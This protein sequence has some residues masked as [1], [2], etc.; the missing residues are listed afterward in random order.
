MRHI[1]QVLNTVLEKDFGKA[2]K[3]IEGFVERLKVEKRGLSLEY[4]FLPD[5]VELYGLVDFEASVWAFEKITPLASC[6]FAVRPFIV[7]YPEKM[8]S[9]MLDWSLSTNHLLR[10]LA[11]EGSRPRLPWAMALL[12]FK[13]DP[14]KM[15]PILENLK[16]DESEFVRKSVANSLNDISKDNPEITLEIVKNW[17]G[18][19]K[20]V[21]RIL[22]HGSRTL[23]KQGNQKA[24]SLFGYGSVD[25]INLSNFSI[26][27]KEIKIGD[28]L[29]FSFVLENQNSKDVNIRLEYA[30]YYRKANESLFK[31]VF[32]ISEKTYS[33]KSVTKIQRRRSFQAFSTRKYHSG[34]HQVAIIVNGVEFLSESFMLYG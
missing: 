6:E 28:Y 33:K 21:D 1:A 17:Q 19:S 24:L 27:K 30:V 16:N 11:S 15:L 2:V 26:A 25:N 10:R 8:M 4:M 34:R 5:Y 3:Q 9:Q 31:K 13:K 18:K 7:K 32:K 23:L 22:K 12:D 29:E 20:N 14:T